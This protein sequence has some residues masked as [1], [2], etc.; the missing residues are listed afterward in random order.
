MRIAQKKRYDESDVEALNKI[1]FRAGR[2]KTF[3]L[4]LTAFGAG[5]TTGACILKW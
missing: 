4:A 3:R 1:A 2:N 5:L